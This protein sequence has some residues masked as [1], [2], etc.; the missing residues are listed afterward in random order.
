MKAKADGS[1]KVSAQDQTEIDLIAGSIGGS[2]SAGI[3]AAISI[4]IITKSTKAYIGAGAIVDALANNINGISVKTGKFVETLIPDPLGVIDDADEGQVPSL[5]DTGEADNSDYSD[6]RIVTAGEITGFKGVAVSAVN[7]DDLAAWSAGLG[8]AAEGAAVQFST[9]INVMSNDTLAYIDDNAQVNQAEGAGDDQSVMVVAGNDYSFKGLARGISGAGEGVALTPAVFV[10]V[11]SN[12]TK[13]YIGKL[14][15]VSAKDDIL[16]AAYA[17]EDI[18]SL[19]VAIAGSGEGS[20]GAGAILVV[21]LDAVTYA[22]ID[23]GATVD[24]DGNLR[25]SA[26]DQT[27]MDAIIGSLGF[28]GLGGGVGASVGVASLS[29]DTRAFIAADAIINAR[30]NSVANLSVDNGDLSDQGVFG[31]NTDVHGL[32]V[33]ATLI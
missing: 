20:G 22:F 31:Q 24:A 2:M 27:E 16:V 7:Q 15:E 12:T 8:I 30:G 5:G 26:N 4:P 33:E 14:A 19:A 6:K 3:S 21:D 18:L 29:K 17:T 11:I 23:E 9:A 32:V 1:V 13:A 25:V 28:A 10:G